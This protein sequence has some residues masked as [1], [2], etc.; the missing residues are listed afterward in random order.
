MGKHHNIFSNDEN[1]NPVLKICPLQSDDCLTC[2]LIIQDYH[3]N[4]WKNSVELQ[5][6]DFL[7][8]LKFEVELNGLNNDDIIDCLN[9]A[10][11]DTLFNSNNTHREFILK[12]N[13]GFYGY[14][15]PCSF[16]FMN[17]SITFEL[18]SLNPFPDSLL[19]EVS[20]KMKKNYY[21]SEI[22]FNFGSW[23]IV[24][25]N[26][27]QEKHRRMIDRSLSLLKTENFPINQL[28]SFCTIVS[29]GLTPLKF[30]EQGIV[31]RILNRQILV[32]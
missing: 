14:F 31:N 9:E 26:K 20:R 24:D 19:K 2:Q 28:N 29:A 11:N 8:Y 22:N 13:F 17:S 1:G 12:N 16:D 18:V 30:N 32:V 5:E 4:Q 7:H 21:L 25:E 10:I 6:W 27:L 23:V 15:H 3:F